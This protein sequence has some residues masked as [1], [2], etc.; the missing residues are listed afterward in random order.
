MTINTPV[1]SIENTYNP[2]N[3][4]TDQEN[5]FVYVDFDNVENYHAIEIYNLNGKRIKSY[6]LNSSSKKYHHTI[7][8][9]GFS[10]GM[11][12]LGIQGKNSRFTR[13]FIIY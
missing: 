5:G 1:G 10:K 4:I 13:K 9:S 12:L 8:I 7:D 11:Y 6:R 2:F 3:I